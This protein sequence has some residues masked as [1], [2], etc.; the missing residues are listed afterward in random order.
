M[1][2]T[3]PTIFFIDDEQSV[4]DGLRRVLHDRTGEWRMVFLTDP[5]VALERAA[6]EA[7]W[8]AVVDIRMPGMDG[9]DL[10]RHL[11]QRQ[12]DL[13]CIVLSGSTD[14]DVAVSSINEG[15]VF[16]Y[17][18]KPVETEVLTNGIEAAIA[19]RIE[20]MKAET[21]PA[22]EPVA[23][24]IDAFGA[25]PFAIFVADAAGKVVHMNDKAGRLIARGSGLVLDAANI[26]RALDQTQ[27]ARLH[28]AMR[29]ARM[30]QHTT[31][32]SIQ[33][34]NGAPVRITVQP[35]VGDQRAGEDLICLFAFSEADRRDPDP[36]L[37]RSMFGLTIAESRLAAALATGADLDDA[38]RSCGVTK[39]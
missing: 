12:P 5:L 32:L 39:S 23:L 29:E 19:H 1:T 2:D 21:K 26:C 15:N 9:L 34:E 37:L 13:V 27:T 28:D 35:Y 17:F 7:P 25:N 18:V 14:F 4:L 10:S 33:G 36:A 16:R 11:R 38:A 24:D 22:L 30:D 31:A 8:V 6:E 20:R 3:R